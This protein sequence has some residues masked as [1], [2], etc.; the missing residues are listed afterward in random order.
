[1]ATKPRKP[2]ATEAPAPAA[3]AWAAHLTPLASHNVWLAGLGM[4][5]AEE[6]AALTA[7]VEALERALGQQPPKAAK[8]AAKRAA[9]RNKN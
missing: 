9:P 2:P 8:P 4:P 5:K 7:R 6:L 3:P 1:M